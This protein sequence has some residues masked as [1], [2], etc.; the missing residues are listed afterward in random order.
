[1][2]AWSAIQLWVA[3]GRRGRRSWGSGE[4]LLGGVHEKVQAQPLIHSLCKERWI[5]GTPSW[6]QIYLSDS[7]TASMSL[8]NQLRSFGE[9]FH[10]RLHE[11]DGLIISGCLICWKFCIQPTSGLGRWEHLSVWLHGFVSTLT[12]YFGNRN[13]L[14]WVFSSSLVE[15]PGLFNAI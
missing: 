10:N 15:A 14:F 1:M 2:C 5:S 11:G 13:G 3:R 9:F 4:R 7:D 6:M 12:E 8:N